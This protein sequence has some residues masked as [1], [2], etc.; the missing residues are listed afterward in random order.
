MP[1][2]LEK[3]FLETVSRQLVTLPYDMK[4]LFDAITDEELEH[5]AR[6]QAAERRIVPE[7]I[8]LIAEG[9]VRIESGRVRVSRA[10]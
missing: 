1:D 10:G 3:R 5:S 2:P 9:R 6:V 8:R 7:A 4:I